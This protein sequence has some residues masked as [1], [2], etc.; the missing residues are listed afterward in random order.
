[1]KTS[2]KDKK[3][4]VYALTNNLDGKKY[5]GLTSQKPEKRWNNGNGYRDTTHIGRAINKYGWENFSHEIIYKNITC[6]EAQKY[7]IELIEKYDTLNPQKG[8]NMQPGGNLSN[9]G[10]KMSEENRQKLSERSKGE[11][12]YF[13][14][15]TP[16]KEHIAY[17]TVLTKE[18]VGDKHPMYGKHHSE[19]SKK[20]MS[21]SAKGKHVGKD[22]YM[23]EAVI[24]LNTMQI[25]ESMSLAEQS[26]E[27][28]FLGGQLKN[29]IYMTGKDD[30]NYF[31]LFWMRY[32][33]FQ[34]Y[35][36]EEVE[37]L[38]EEYKYIKDFRVILLNTNTLYNSPQIASDIFDFG[39]CGAMGIRRACKS[40]SH[41]YKK[42]KNGNSYK[43]MYYKDYKKK[44][45]I[46]ALTI[47]DESTFLVD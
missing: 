16:T 17:L 36:I 1:M 13:Y 23:S 9:L 11:K 21:K 33:E 43:W 38:L 12:N 19:E 30:D 34:T 3:F 39:D 41:I 44:N 42:D 24:C 46:S 6:E 10:I 15:K 47:F 31:G 14:G 4:Y 27:S 32:D 5:I 40:E 29:G 7:E 2:A 45:D 26:H 22:N 25:Y 8:Y 28:C 20:K 35:T 37:N 18:R